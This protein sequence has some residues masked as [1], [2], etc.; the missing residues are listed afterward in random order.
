M[1]S[2]DYDHSSRTV[3][4]RISSSPTGAP[5]SRTNANAVIAV[6]Q[7][8][9]DDGSVARALLTRIGYPRARIPAFTR[10]DVFWTD[11][12]LNLERGILV[13]GIRRVLAEAAAE[14]PGNTA[15]A[16]LLALAGGAP[17]PAAAGAAPIPVLVLLSDPYRA[18]KLRLD[19]EARFF[20]DADGHGLRV[21][22]RQATRTGDIV[23]ALRTAKPRILHFGG[24][25]MTNGNLVFEDDAGRRAEVP[26]TE[27]AAAIA[28]T[29]G[30]L[31]CVVLN[32]CY[33]ATH[34]QAFHAVARAVAGAVGDLPDDTALGFAKGFYGAVGAGEP[35]GKAFLQGSAE[36][37]LAGS[38]TS[39]LHF[40]DFDQT[41]AAR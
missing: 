23:T 18:S 16:A 1:A 38:P 10:A 36:A 26:L 14:N 2:R 27:L 3:S 6:L 34:A 13:D 4:Y 25:G 30:R 5:V 41:G 35:A 19:R 37:G 8:L 11:V 7:E 20:G 15:V 29:V 31:D 32:S 22:V 17:A 24:H 39:G 28:A 33:T 12:V 40:V 21:T 9:Y